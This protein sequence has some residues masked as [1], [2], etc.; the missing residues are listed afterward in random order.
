MAEIG[1]AALTFVVIGGIYIA[2]YGP[3]RTPLGVPTALLIASGLLVA[4]NVVM[5][6]RI[7]DLAWDKFF[8]VLR[9][10]LVVYLIAAGL[11]EFAIVHNHTRAGALVV[12]TLML[13]VFAVDVPMIISF[14]VAR[15]QGASEGAE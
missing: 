5:V 13:I 2:S 6:A 4:V 12:I 1:V 11:I 14:T 10:T 9:R 8:L 3:R 15:H 7:R